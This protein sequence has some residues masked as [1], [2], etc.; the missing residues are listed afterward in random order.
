LSNNRIK[1][2]SLSTTYTESENS[3]K[4]AFVHALNKELSRRGIDVTVICPH[5]ENYPTTLKSD[6]VHIRSFRYLP[7]KYQIN[8]QSI[9]DEIKSL[10]GKLKVIIMMTGFFVYA[11]NLCLR[12]QDY[13]LHG[14][15]AFPSGY[16]SYVMSRLFKKKF[17]VTVH[18]S[19]IPLVEK[20]SFLKKSVVNSLNKAS[21]VIVGNEF[22]KEK[23]IGWGVTKQKIV[24]IKPIP[25]FVEHQSDEKILINFKKQ[26]TDPKNKIILFVGKLT[27]VKGIEYLISSIPALTINNI[28]LIIVGEGI[29]LEKLKKLV[30]KLN[31]EEK[32]TFFGPADR[33]Q[34]GLLY[35]I[36]DVFVMPSIV[37]KNGS[38]EGTG[39]VIP[40]AMKSG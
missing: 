37:T 35:D 33:K 19:D 18:G 6:D 5:T 1:L 24:I 22:L 13:L 32:I 7:E 34:L 26:F 16:I 27:E 12:D 17:I 2:Y 11:F 23:L 40:E 9:P 20:F 30:Q 21:Y 29:L 14:H 4:P 39:L 28:H 10:K 15:W 38:T 8:S 31:V 3:T 25:N 36:S